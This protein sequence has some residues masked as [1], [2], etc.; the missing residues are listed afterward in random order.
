MKNGII[1]HKSLKCE[2]SAAYKHTGPLQA[3]LDEKV[4]GR[5]KKC[6]SYLKSLYNVI[7]PSGTN[8]RKK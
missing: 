8:P 2:H 5:T 3:L 4:D 1:K 6:G 7:Y